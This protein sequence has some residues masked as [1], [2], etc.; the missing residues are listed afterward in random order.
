MRAGIRNLRS[1]RG[2]GSEAWKASPGVEAS[3]LGV[4]RRAFTLIEVLLAVAV[5]AIVLVAMHGVFYGALRLRNKT[6]TAME[7]A[8]P[9]QQALAILKRDLA[10]IVLPGGT[11]FGEFQT[12]PTSGTSQSAT[13]Q[14]GQGTSGITSGM[15]GGISGAG[16][17][18]NSAFNSASMKGLVVG[19]TFCTTVGSIDDTAPWGEVERV[20]YYLANPTNNTPGKDLIRSVTRNLLPMAQDQPL[21]QWLLSGVQTVSFYFYDGNAWG[22]TWDSTQQTAK[23]PQAIKVE[24]QLVS[25]TPEPKL[26]EPITLVVPVSVQAATNQ[27][28]QATGGGQ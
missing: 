20:L 17:T 24:I 9:L 3:E 21:D 6:A 19:P 13:N 16:S 15:S 1:E 27:T 4:R 25:E 12:T 28:E 18:I 10:N 7:E 14:T 26:R 2:P 8:V 5:F 23:V 22:E 11:L